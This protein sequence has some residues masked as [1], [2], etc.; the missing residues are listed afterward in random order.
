MITNK[1]EIVL[2][3]IEKIAANESL[4]IIGPKKGKVLARIIREVQPMHVLELGTLIGYSTILIGTNLRRDSFLITLEIKAKHART[5]KRNIQRAEIFPVVEVIVG[6]AKEVIPQ[7]KGPFDLIFIDAEKREYIDY[8]R[9][10]EKKIH[11]GSLVVAD[12]AVIFSEE[13]K[14]YLEYVRS[15]GKYRSKLILIDADGLEVSTKL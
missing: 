3:E 1:S 10:V 14:D 2:R 8:L 7:L 15:S 9:L 11:K 12:N 13:V 6:D 5:A 4:P